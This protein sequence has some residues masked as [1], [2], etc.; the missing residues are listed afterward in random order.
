MARAGKSARVA[1][2]VS[3]HRRPL[4]AGKHLKHS[5]RRRVIGSVNPPKKIDL[6]KEINS[7][8][9]RP[10]LGSKEYYLES[11]SS[12]SSEDEEASATM[13][14][15]PPLIWA[16]TS[17]KDV[18][19]EDNQSIA[20]RTTDSS[21]EEE[22]EE[23]EEDDDDNEPKDITDKGTQYYPNYPSVLTYGE[24]FE[25]S[26]SCHKPNYCDDDGEW[27]ASK[28]LNPR[29]NLRNSS[30]QDTTGLSSYHYTP[31]DNIETQCYG[32]DPSKDSHVVFASQ[33]QGGVLS[34]EL[35]DDHGIVHPHS[36][37][38]T[39]Y[40]LPSFLL[41]IRQL[42]GLIPSD[43]HHFYPK[44]Q[45]D[46]YTFSYAWLKKPVM[47]FIDKMHD[48]FLSTKLGIIF[49]QAS[50][51]VHPVFDDIE[52]IRFSDRKESYLCHCAD[53][54]RCR[55]LLNAVKV[56]LKTAFRT[57]SEPDYSWIETPGH[58]FLG[59]V[60]V[61]TSK[62]GDSMTAFL[63]D[64]FL[65]LQKQF[66]DN[67]DPTEVICQHF[68]AE[69]VNTTMSDRLLQLCQLIP[70]HNKKNTTSDVMIQFQVPIA[71]K[72]TI[73]AYEHMHTWVR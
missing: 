55:V 20:T 63:V 15:I 48:E 51:F 59:F 32:I 28:S 70:F 6:A 45:M 25:T 11:S 27:A 34:S 65:I 1:T 58:Q 62:K 66:Q 16:T 17:A 29:P 8:Y 56:V 39:V 46:D 7:M 18:A 21:E 43:H 10:N 42:N 61:Y 26:V 54:S 50:K 49:L 67:S 3:Q 53:I 9:Q 36:L 52:L 37:S 22:E 38:D 14:N 35:G 30:I 57:Q 60:T 40:C 71:L 2:K 33:C 44:N 68:S 19:G 31:L 72:D 4:R 5:T 23:E 69:Y 47:S 12:E 73:L 13:G 41:K 64:S 24:S